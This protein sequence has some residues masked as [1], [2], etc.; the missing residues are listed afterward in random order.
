M[1]LRHKPDYLAMKM[2]P[3]KDEKAVGF[4]AFLC[5]LKN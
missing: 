1:R 4:L 2:E 3:N 5:F